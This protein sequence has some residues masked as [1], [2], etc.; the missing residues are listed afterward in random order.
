MNRTAKDTQ[1]SGMILNDIVTFTFFGIIT[2]LSRL[3]CP[4]YCFLCCFILFSSMLSP[5][6]A[7]VDGTERVNRLTDYHDGCIRF[8]AGSARIPWIVGI[9]KLF[10]TI[11]IH[12]NPLGSFG[13]HLKSVGI[14][15][16]PFEIIRNYLRSQILRGSRCLLVH[17][18]F[19]NSI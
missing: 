17:L 7:E 12:W 8:H 13:I 10:E 18:N 14:H 9:R 19:Y 16:N 6:F 4:G 3:Y 2:A 5:S 1:L 11:G 15:S